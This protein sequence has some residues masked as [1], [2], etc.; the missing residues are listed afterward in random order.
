MA[1]EYIVKVMI[2]LVVVAVV[3]GLMIRFSGD[4]KRK[5]ADLFRKENEYPKFPQ[6]KENARFGPREIAAYVQS[7]HS[8]MS[9]LPQGQ[10]RDEICYLLK[11]DSPFSTFCDSCS[12]K[13]RQSLPN[14]LLRVTEIAATFNKEIIKI[15]YVDIGDRILISD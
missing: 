9:S 10:Q 6:I 7:C 8:L 2:L 1:F 11:A 4:I 3:V 14:D 15:S 5:V 12:Q 13:I